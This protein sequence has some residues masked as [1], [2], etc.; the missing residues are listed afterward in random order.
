[1]N[2]IIKNLAV[3]TCLGWAACETPIGVDRV[4]LD[5]AYQQITASALTGPEV[6]AE[7]LVV[8]GR[9]GL[10]KVAAKNPDVAVARLQK[11]ACADQ[12]RAVWF[13]LAD[14]SYATAARYEHSTWVTIHQP[15]EIT[16]RT[17]PGKRA[18]RAYYFASAVY[19]YFYLFGA[20]AAAPDPF[21]RQYRMV[22]DF[23]NRGLAKALKREN[24]EGVDLTARDVKLPMG[25]VRIAA[26]RPGFRWSEK[27]FHEFVA[28]DEYR[29]R[30]LRPRERV[31]GLGVPL[32]ATPDWSAAAGGKRPDFYAAD[33]RVPAT[34]FLR[35]EGTVCDMT[36]SRL[37]ATLELY[38]SF[39]AHTVTVGG[40]TVPLEMDHTAPVAYGLQHSVQWK[41]RLTQFFTGCE[42]IKSGIYLTEPY[43]PGKIPI[44]F[45]YGTSG[46]PSDWAPAFNALR[47]D[48]QI[49]TQYQFWFFVYNTG[50]PIAYSGWRLRAGLDKII[51]ELDPAGQDPALRNL[52]VV[53][54]SQGG[55]VTKLVAVDSSDHFWKLISDRPIDEFQV[56][57]E[58]R[59]LLRNCLFFAHSPYVRRVVLACAPNQGSI[60]VNNFVQNL[61]QRLIRM[62]TQLTR[63][64]TDL[65]TLNLGG[66]NN[67]GLKKLHCK[68]PT[69]VANMNPQN[70]FLRALRDQPLADGVKG[71]TIIGILGDGPKEQANDG[72]VAYTSAHLPGMASEDLVHG[73]HGE[74]LTSPVTVEHLRR[75][76]QTHRQ[77]SRP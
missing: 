1:M 57:A 49:T 22:C 72:V 12:R 4:G 65:A 75:I 10:E 69:S 38:S 32:I 60:L 33:T 41:A 42:L 26:T 43:T 59:E 35:L 44:V 11:M 74:V 66:R 15:D 58:S 39:D 62:P 8:L 36:S 5:R 29:V 2:P 51:K 56:S 14:L 37:K 61:S 6:S 76:L 40:R 63:L 21:D 55:L 48:P 24:S 16:T 53:G 13:A 77:E 54:H 18:A 19:A 27:L 25:E 9:Y 68:V 52:I 67:P 71:H 30:G 70:P 34:A 23:Y 28:A 7:T 20:G 46:S 73:G 50:N 3:L 17:I 45:V 64:G 31:S 47:A